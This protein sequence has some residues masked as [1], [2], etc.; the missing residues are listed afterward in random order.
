MTADC[1]VD[2]I[3]PHKDCEEEQECGLNKT[4]R[5]LVRN[6]GCGC[7][8]VKPAH[9]NDIDSDCDGDKILLRRGEHT[10]LANCGATWFVLTG[11]T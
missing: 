7:V 6:H 10:E 11:A 8:A 3:L 9:G 5:I 4:Q 2:I 1:S